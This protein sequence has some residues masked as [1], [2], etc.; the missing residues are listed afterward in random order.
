MFESNWFFWAFVKLLSQAKDDLCSFSSHLFFS[1]SVRSCAAPVHSV[2]RLAARTIPKRHPL[3]TFCTMSTA[4]PWD[5]L[6]PWKIYRMPWFLPLN[7]GVKSVKFPL[8]QSNDCSLVVSASMI[9]MV[10][11]WILINLVQL[12]LSHY[13]FNDGNY[14]GTIPDESPLYHYI[15]DS[16]WTDVNG[17]YYNIG[18][19]F[20][21]NI[22]N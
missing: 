8:N 16:W 17:K 3:E 9:F 19:V 6:Y 5:L 12:Q 4:R 15:H 13:Y 22:H 7:V 11:H 21:I 1:V 2:F 10:I 20:P 14:S 18:L